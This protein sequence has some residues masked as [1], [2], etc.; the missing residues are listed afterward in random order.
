MKVKDKLTGFEEEVIEQTST[1]WNI[2]QKKRTDKGINCTNW[3]D[4]TLKENKQR[5]IKIEK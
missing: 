3:F 1:S 5:F 2:T 4:M